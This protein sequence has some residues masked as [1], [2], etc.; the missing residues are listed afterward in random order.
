MRIESGALATVPL[1]FEQDLAAL[2]KRPSYFLVRV[3]TSWVS[4]SCL[5]TGSA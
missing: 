2:R 3:I 1:A 4:G 5:T